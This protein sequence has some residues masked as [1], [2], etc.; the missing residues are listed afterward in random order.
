MPAEDRGRHLIAHELVHTLQSGGGRIHRKAM[1]DR[2]GST[3]ARAAKDTIKTRY[4]S[5]DIRNAAWNIIQNKPRVRDA[6]LFYSRIKQSLPASEW[7][8]ELARFFTG[9]YSAKLKLKRNLG[10]TGST[11]EET[12]EETHKIT[13]VNAR[14]HFGRAVSTYLHEMVHYADIWYSSDAA[15]NEGKKRKSAERSEGIEPLSKDDLSKSAQKSAL[16]EA[17]DAI[18]ER[19]LIDMQ[20]AKPHPNEHPSLARKERKLFFKAKKQK[21]FDLKKHIDDRRIDLYKRANEVV[22]KDWMKPG[23]GNTLEL[24]YAFEKAAYGFAETKQ[25]GEWF[26]SFDAKF[27]ILFEDYLQ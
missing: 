19:I 22:Y 14:N 17:L 27:E 15:A 11:P 3:T 21:S 6:F 25:P 9:E 2:G 8:A 1:L 16:P 18:I 4:N 13:K 7:N 5:D 26:D 10:T 12:G 20:Q 23:G 24:G